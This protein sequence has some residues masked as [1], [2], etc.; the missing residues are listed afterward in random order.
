MR[1]IKIATT[2]L[3]IGS[4]FTLGCVQTT[5]DA[6]DEHSELE[7]LQTEEIIDNLVKAGFP[8]SEIDVLDD[9]SVYV[10]GDAH[11]TLEASREM[12]GSPADGDMLKQYRTT[13]LV[14]SPRTISVIGYTGG[15]N[16]LDSTMQTALG[17]AIDNYNRLDIGLT[18]TL[19]FATSTSADIV[20]YKTGSGAGG[21]AGF[22]SGGNP[23]KWVQ[24]F[25]GTSAYGTN[26][27]EHVIT[28]ELGH[29]LGFRHTDYFNRSL[30][31]GSGGNEGDAGGRSNPCPG[32][33]DR[34]RRRLRNAGLLQRERRRRVRP[35]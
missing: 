16:A 25:P 18:F 26:V 33:P 11:V 35:K 29:T 13:N 5:E 19:T 8:L 12:I 34:F 4:L 6:P 7:D 23:Y 10:G 17:W 2:A 32:H 20:V 31:C 15:S 9:D 1:N 22:P 14:S 21:S 27:T 30:S 24:I 28:H 3:A